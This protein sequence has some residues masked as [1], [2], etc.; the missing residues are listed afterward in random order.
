MR[1]KPSLFDVARD[2]NVSHQT[3]SRVLNNHINVRPETKRRVEASV[4][5]LG[6]KVNVSARALATGKYRAIGLLNLN[7]TLYGPITMNESIQKIA[8]E[9]HYRVNYLTVDSI[10]NESVLNGIEMLF[11]TGVDGILVVVPRSLREI[12]LELLKRFRIP[13]VIRDHSSVP[14]EVK[15]NQRLVSSVATDYLISQGHRRIAFAGGE[16]KW[17][18][19]HERM[20]AWKAAM[21]KAN[22]DYDLLFEGNWSASSGYSMAENI[23]AQ[24]KSVTAIYAASDLIGLGVLKYLNDRRLKDISVISTDAMEESEFYFPSL[25]TI[26]Y[27]YEELGRRYFHLLLNLMAKRPMSV[28]TSSLQV[29]LSIRD[30][31]RKHKD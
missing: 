4:A 1:S 12:D 21:K 28:Y 14:K 16:K 7:S 13:I 19:A 6:Y 18:D 30:S 22:L 24:D 11:A 2:A 31:T 8:L 27:D 29:E 20:T 26:K 25:T 9:L 3:V 10:D 23:L 5:K 17:F 15:L